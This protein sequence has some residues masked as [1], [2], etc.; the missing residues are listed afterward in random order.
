MTKLYPLTPNQTRLY[1][2]QT[3]Y[4]N[5]PAYRLTFL[6]KIT[7]N[8]DIYRLKKVLETVCDSIDAFK[9]DFVEVNNNIYQRY[10]DEKKHQFEVICRDANNSPAQFHEQIIKQVSELQKTPLTQWPLLYFTL[11]H[12]GDSENYL[13]LTA[14]HI[15]SDGQ[16]YHLM[17]DAI[18]QAYNN[19]YRGDALVTFAQNY[20]NQRFLT[21]PMYTAVSSKA[22]EF[23]LAE[24]R[25]I[26]SFGVKKIRQHRNERLI[27]DGT[28]AYFYLDKTGIQDYLGKNKYSEN[29]FFLAVHA[30][31]IKKLTSENIIVIGL[32][33]LNRDKTNKNA[34]GYFVNTLPLLINFDQINL[35]S[36]L[37]Q[38]INRKIFSLLR[39]QSYH[40][41]DLSHIDIRFNNYFTFYNK[42]FDYAF[43]QCNV[44]RIALDKDNIMAE[45]KCAVESM[46]DNYL[47]TL[48]YGNYFSK[49]P[50][51]N[52]FKQIIHSIS[53]NDDPLIKDIPV[54]D[55]MSQ[56]KQINSYKTQAIKDRFEET[57]HHNPYN[58]ALNDGSQEWTYQELNKRANKMA[59]CLLEKTILSDKII[60]S[61]KRDNHLVLVILAILK[62]GKCYVPIDLHC[63]T[64]RFNYILKDLDDTFVIG[65]NEIEDLIAQSEQY[66]D[67]DLHINVPTD[68]PAYM[69][70]TSGSTGAPKGVLVSNHNLL[71]LMDACKEKFDFNSADVW[72]LFHSYGFDFSVW[73]IFACL[74]EGSKLIILDRQLTQSPSHYYE[75]MH[76][77]GVTVLNQTPTAFM[78]IIQEDLLQKKHLKLRYVIFGGEALCFPSLKKWVER[79]PL[80]TVKLVNMYGITETT[81]HVTY[82]EVST[83]DLDSSQSIIGKPLDHLGIQIINK[84]GNILPPGIPGEI[85]IFGEGVTNGYYKNTV[86][87]QSKFINKD[88]SPFTYYKS[89]NLGYFNERGDIVYLG[90]MDRQIQLRGYRIELGEIESSMIKSAFVKD[91]AVDMVS[92]GDNGNQRIVAYLVPESHYEESLLKQSLK[93][94]LLPYMIPS[95][96][97]LVDN[98]PI[99]VNGKVDLNLLKSRINIQ[100]SFMKGSTTTERF[101]FELISIAINHDNFSLEENLFDMG[102]TSIDLVS[103]FARIKEKFPFRQ[104]SIL[105]VFQFPTIKKLAD[106]IDKKGNPVNKENIAL[107]RSDIRKSLLKKRMAS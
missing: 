84:D 41:D 29:S 73:E 10:S 91:C 75:I 71:S 107:D 77:H 55:H 49:I 12:S 87:S 65:E 21:E 62:I 37:V 25:N 90:R 95:L 48:E 56:Y 53:S 20:F 99:T 59:R 40:I 43:N 105:D 80:E 3:A 50:V 67:S 101:L 36:E 54:L 63:P 16:S 5:D 6:Y 86:L 88:K 13:L 83:K 1:N 26:D 42:P 17:I 38:Y 15:I 52:I 31:F 18:N 30:L 85:L 22:R 92:L 11:Y 69:I 61:L 9:V 28:S 45:F 58:I 39:H 14:S 23:F 72:M 104:F 96:F 81:I 47:V 35:F 100:K 57:A 4:P 34:F 60:I 79:H 74:L 103:I 32:P 66:D 97:I 64:E 27:L 102:V 19:E 68:A 106:H 7:G 24:T 70:Y 44:Q 51:E 46:Q 93:A 98:I 76:K 8:L 94:F 78:G 82:H 89:G 33:I 2:F